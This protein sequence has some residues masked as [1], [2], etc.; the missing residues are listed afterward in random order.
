MGLS[1]PRLDFNYIDIKVRRV[2]LKD[3]S[4]SGQGFQISGVG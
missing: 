2:N 1:K 3:S 4:F